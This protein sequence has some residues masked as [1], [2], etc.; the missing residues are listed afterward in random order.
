MKLAR[1]KFLNLAAG[2]VALPVISRIAQAQIYPTRPV[3]QVRALSQVVGHKENP[4]CDSR[5]CAPVWAKG[6]M[7]AAV[8]PM[9]VAK[10]KTR[11]KSPVISGSNRLGSTAR[12][13]KLWQWIPALSIS[14]P[15]APP[16]PPRNFLYACGG[17]GLR[18]GSPLLTLA[19][20]I[21]LME[22]P[23]IGLLI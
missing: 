5:L 10:I 19:A 22:Q 17:G 13:L 21:R 2:A 12:R 7:S 6:P 23:F 4:L 14:C 3:L 16:A 15:A 18:R 20:C 11:L 1:R 9:D 8:E